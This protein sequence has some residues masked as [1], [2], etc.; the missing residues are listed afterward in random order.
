MLKKGLTFLLFSFSILNLFGQSITEIKLNIGPIYNRGEIGLT[1]EKGVNKN[2]SLE[3]GVGFDKT[4][5]AYNTTFDTLT[6]LSTSEYAKANRL[7]LYLKGLTYPL[8]KAEQPNTGLIV[9]VVFRG[10][11][12]TFI[13]EKYPFDLPKPI[14]RSGLYFGYKW[15]INNRIPIEIGTEWNGTIRRLYGPG[16]RTF[17][18]EF[19]FHAK[20]G[21]RFMNAKR[22]NL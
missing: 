4:K 22:L 12:F 13:E 14:F 18:L 9:G 8:A 15:L 1:F 7:H 17:D 21:Y 2:F 20:F 16:S 6:F 10:E 19:L 3:V 11:I 5:R